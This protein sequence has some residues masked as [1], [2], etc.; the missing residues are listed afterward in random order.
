VIL[1]AKKQKTTIVLSSAKNIKADEQEPYK[2]NS[3]QI[4]EKTAEKTLEYVFFTFSACIPIETV[5]I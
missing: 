3:D 4:T 1:L 2:E 5:I